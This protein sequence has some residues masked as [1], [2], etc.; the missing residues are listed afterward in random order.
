MSAPT[1]PTTGEATVSRPAPHRS[2]PTPLWSADVRTDDDCLADLGTDWD[3]LFAR[4]STATPFQS[5]AWLASWWRTYGRPG[6]LR[7]VLVRYAGRLVA[8][9]PLMLVHRGAVAVLTPIGGDLSDFADVLVDDTTTEAGTPTEDGQPKEIVVEAVRILAETLIL[10][11]GWQA[12]DVAETRPDAT[13]GRLLAVWPGPHR[14]LPGSPC[15]ELPA[16]PIDELVADLPTHTRKTVRRR[17]N[18]LRRLDLD[19]RTV[20]ADDIDRAVADLLR[21]HTVQWRGR[22][23]NP[24]HA[25]PEF[26]RHLSGAVAPMTVAGQAALI[27]YRISG[28]LM[29][30]SLVI[31]GRDMV[32]GYLYG[33]DPALREVADVTTMLLVDTLAM[34]HRSGRPTMSMLR[35]AESHKLRW[36]PAEAVNRRLLLGRPGS[37]R[38]LAY[39]AGVRTGRAAVRAAKKRLPWLVTARAA[40]R[41]AVHTTAR[42][43]GRD[44]SR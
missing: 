19:T 44:E 12:V 4:C 32:G 17:L 41:R 39:L 1:T 26:A 15:L 9:A 25:R 34:A 3:D 24:E 11:P 38:G 37:P 16:R 6:R 18:Q 23:I 42:P 22:G 36:R 28:R 10:T 33:A 7:L 21:L 29:A 30:S 2:V 35:G 40:A 27:E 31:V 43:A 20:S 5:Y 8:A 13:V 14:A